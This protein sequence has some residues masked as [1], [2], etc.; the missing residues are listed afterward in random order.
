MDKYDLEQSIFE[1][2]SLKIT[3][4]SKGYSIDKIEED[5][6]LA[7]LEYKLYKKRAIFDKEKISNI[8]ITDLKL[9]CEQNGLNLLDCCNLNSFYSFISFI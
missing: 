4:S 9:Y 7:S 1:D 6:Q 5:Q 2:P 3:L 8:I